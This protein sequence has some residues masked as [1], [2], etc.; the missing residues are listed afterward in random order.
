ML[1]IMEISAVHVIQVT[2]ARLVI[3]T[4]HAVRVPVKME[5]L[6]IMKPI[7]VIISVIV[8]LTTQALIAKLLSLVTLILARTVEPV[9]IL[10]TFQV[11]PV[12]AVLNTRE[13]T[14][15]TIFR[16]VRVRVKMAE[17]VTMW[18]QFQ[19]CLET[20]RRREF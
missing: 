9:L 6:V 18:K 11:T 1:T 4:S 12:T 10:E 17:L 13:P 16:V 20:L 2:L 7:L 5:Q 8:Q 3:L 15:I 14:V 19:E